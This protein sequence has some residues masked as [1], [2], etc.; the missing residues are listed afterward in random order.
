MARKLSQPRYGGYRVS[1]SGVYR[2]LRRFGLSTRFERRAT[3]EARSLAQVGLATERA[4]RRVRAAEGT[5]AVEAREPGE[6]LCLDAFYVG[7]LKGV[8]RL[9]QFTA[10]DAATR[11]AWRGSWSTTRRP[12]RPRPS[13]RRWS[14]PPSGRPGTG[15]GPCSPTMVLSSWATAFREALT[16]AGA[17]HRRTRPRR[18]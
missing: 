1:P 13:S 12:A 17:A 3:S 7:K 9:W 11:F 6:L 10:V 5:R 2:C 14:C 4:W 16:R 8:G 15:S 18:P